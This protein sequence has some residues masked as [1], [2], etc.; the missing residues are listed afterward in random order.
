M[1]LYGGKC[2]ECGTAQM[3]LDFSST[4]PRICVKCHARDKF[5]DYRFADKRGK[6]VSFSNDYLSAVDDPPSTLTVVDYEGGG[7]GAFEMTDRDPD[8]VKVGTVV[9]MTFRKMFTAREGI[10]NYFWKCKPYRG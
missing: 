6:V 3:Y 8:E 4:R 10:Y 2:K 1:A 9:E 5:E 7:R